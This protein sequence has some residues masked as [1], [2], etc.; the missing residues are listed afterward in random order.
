MSPRHG[1]LEPG[2]LVSQTEASR[3]KN[4]LE[5]FSQIG[6]VEGRREV[7]AS[8]ALERDGMSL[9]SA[10]PAV[11]PGFFGFGLLL[12]RLGLGINDFLSRQTDYLKSN[13]RT[14]SFHHMTDV[15]TFAGPSKSWFALSI[16]HFL[17]PTLRS[18]FPCYCFDAR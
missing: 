10:S 12:L 14:L 9:V 11:V 16:F 3:K 8:W 6:D 5:P 2:T 13:F 18:C 15:C 1:G 4:S 7:M 17:C